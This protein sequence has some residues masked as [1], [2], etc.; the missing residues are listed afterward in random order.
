M[1]PVW[2][3]NH[4]WLVFVLIITWTGFPQVFEAVVSTTWIAVDPRR[5]RHR[6][7]RRGIRRSASR[8]VRLARRR[9]YGEVF[10]V[11]SIVAPFFLAAALGGV[12]SG[13]VPVGNRAGDPV[14]SWLNPTSRAVRRARG[15]A[16]PRSSRP[17]SSPPTPAGSASRTSRPTSGGGRCWPAAAVLAVA[18]V[19]LLVLRSDARHV[20]DG[21]LAGWGLVFAADR[22]RRHR[23]DHGAGGPGRPPR[24]PA[25]RD[26]RAGVAGAGLGHGAAAVP[27]ADV[28]HRRRRR[29]RPGQPALAGHRHGRRRRRGRLPPWPCS[30]G[31]T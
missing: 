29:R 24:H 19:G 14:T 6:A 27:A 5:A 3:A 28:A 10:G 7:A 20:F 26:R 30:T 4:V 16:R 15:R 12:A 1:A 9:R 11:A 22:A 25:D 31:W 18:L 17:C 13:R 23:G 21:L 8:P 2:E